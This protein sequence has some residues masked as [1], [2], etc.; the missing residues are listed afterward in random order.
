MN[1]KLLLCLFL[2]F[3]LLLSEYAHADDAYD[4]CYAAFK[5]NIE[6]AGRLLTLNPDLINARSRNRG[7]TPLHYAASVGDEKMVLFLLSKGAAINSKDTFGATPLHETVN[8]G[9]VDLIQIL[10]SRGAEVNS[11]T[12]IQWTPLHYAAAYGYVDSANALL[13]LGANMESRDVVGATPLH[14]AAESGS[15]DVAFLLFKSGANI[16]SQTT[17]FK[18]TPLHCAILHGR[19]D[20]VKF[21]LSIGADTSLKDKGGN[22]ALSLA[23]EYG[24]QEL[25]TMIQKAG[26]KK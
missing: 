7:K 13:S 6:E 3:T 26:G 5:G 8:Y 23:E 12:D 24:N 20:M 15:V 17:A 14:T 19:R 1:Q 21:L 22:T 18:L 25:I 2:A 4:I 16:N 9:N 10:K 11:L